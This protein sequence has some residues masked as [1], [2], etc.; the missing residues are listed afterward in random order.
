MHDG[1][2][3]MKLGLRGMPAAA[4]EIM[5]RRDIA[6]AEHTG[7]RI[8]LMGLSSKNSVDEVRQA[9]QRGIRVTADVTPHHLTL[10]DACLETYDANYKVDPPLRTQPAY[11][12]PDRRLAGRDDR[13]HQLPIINPGRRRRKPIELD[14]CAVRHHRTGDADPDLRAD[15]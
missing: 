13:P 6:L 15:R 7:S 10:T 12:R 1:F 11:R 8:H 5:V 9:K 14:L 3:A 2:Y 4:E